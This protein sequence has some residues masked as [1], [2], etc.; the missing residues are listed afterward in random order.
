[1][2]ITTG[3]WSTIFDQSERIRQENDE[4]S[5]GREPDLTGMQQQML[6]ST[7]SL[8]CMAKDQS[9]FPRDLF[10]INDSLSERIRLLGRQFE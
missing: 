7:F 6:G 2:V 5:N 4:T 9:L 8:V 10:Y 3:E 1:M